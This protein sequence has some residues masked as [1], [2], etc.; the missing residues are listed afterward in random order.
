MSQKTFETQ[1]NLLSVTQ[2][3]LLKTV[4]QNENITIDL[5]KLQEMTNILIYEVSK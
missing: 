1:H 4:E 2:I 5:Q 3:G